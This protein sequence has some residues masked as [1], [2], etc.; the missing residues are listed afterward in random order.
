MTLVCRGATPNAKECDAPT[1]D[2]RATDAQTFARNRYS[3][4]IH[5]ADFCVD[6]YMKSIRIHHPTSSAAS[7]D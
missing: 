1:D 3:R 5:C 4:C 7:K 6:F 2:D